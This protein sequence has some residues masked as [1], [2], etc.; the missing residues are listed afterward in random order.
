MKEL[1]LLRGNTMNTVKS[2]KEL[3]IRQGQECSRIL[4]ELLPGFDLKTLEYDIL[5]QDN[6]VNE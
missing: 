4:K 3:K 1:E 5:S 6:E 2:F